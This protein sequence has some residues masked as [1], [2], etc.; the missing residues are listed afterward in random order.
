M[1]KHYRTAM[2]KQI[3]IDG[4]RLVNEH[5]IAVGN[6]KVNA[7]GDELGPGGR[8]VR[9]KDQ[10]MKEYYA[11]NT[12]VATDDVVIPSIQA[13][14]DPQV[15][16]DP[17]S[18]M[19]E[20]DEG[21]SVLDQP[22]GLVKK[23]TSIFI[24]VTPPVVEVREPVPPAA[25]L[26]VADPIPEPTPVVVKAPIVQPVAVRA[27]IVQPPPAPIVQPEPVVVKAPVVQPDPAPTPVVVQAPIVQQMPAPP[28]VQPPNM[29]GV[30]A[31]SIAKTATI[32][33]TP[34]LPPKKAGGVQRF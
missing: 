22:V 23:E 34:K 10:I 18:G 31:S 13:T 7:R 32:T 27:P 9:T 8:I 24:P 6:M 15:T 11:L 21:P 16:V 19:D 4:L 25:S 20:I 28:V 2:G 1:T 12:P 33:Q 17:N 14:A 5:V 3:D 26:P 29:R 30:L